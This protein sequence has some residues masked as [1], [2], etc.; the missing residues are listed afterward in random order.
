[1]NV[2]INQKLLDL[3]E[4]RNVYFTPSGVQRLKIGDVIKVDPNSAIEPYT[5]FLSGNAFWNMGSFSYSWSPLK[6]TVKIG[7]YSSIAIGSRIF[8]P[9]HPYERFTSSS[10]TLDRSFVIFSKCV[11]SVEKNEFITKPIPTPPHNDRQ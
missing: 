1:M 4:E 3:F 9:Q 7:R 5:G 6:F 10:V 8:G 2:K 11:N